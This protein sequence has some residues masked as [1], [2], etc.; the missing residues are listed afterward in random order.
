MRTHAEKRLKNALDSV[1]AETPRVQKMKEDLLKPYDR[2][3]TILDLS[4]SGVMLID[5]ETNSVVDVNQVAANMFGESKN[6]IIGSICHKHVC[7]A[8]AGKYPVTDPGMTVDSG[9][10]LV[11]T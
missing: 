3:R 1:H 4:P 5:P 7:P 10:R 11:A 2:Y 9:G 8:E 6:R